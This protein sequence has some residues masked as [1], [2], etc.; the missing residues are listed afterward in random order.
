MTSDWDLA[1]Q[2]ILPFMDGLRHVK[3]IAADSNVDIELVRAC[4]RQLL[5]YRCASLIDIFQVWHSAFLSTWMRFL[6]CLSTPGRPVF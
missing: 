2:E 5:F 4:V 3:R 1:L 6:I